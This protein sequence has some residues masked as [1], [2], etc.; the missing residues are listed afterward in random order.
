MCIDELR[1]LHIMHI[2]AV[3]REVSFMNTMF[4]ILISV[5]R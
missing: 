5:V 3:K 1:D 4:R 2:I